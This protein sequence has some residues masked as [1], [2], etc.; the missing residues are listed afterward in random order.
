MILYLEM[1]N[2]EE[3]DTVRGKSRSQLHIGGSKGTKCLIFTR[4]KNLAVSGVVSL[5]NIPVSARSKIQKMSLI[6]IQM[7]H[8]DIVS[9]NNMMILI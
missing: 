7:V 1:E 2:P 6:L 9:N 3:R 5:G 4:K 8:C